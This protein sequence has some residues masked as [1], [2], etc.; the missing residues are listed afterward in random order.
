MA[1][2]STT[3]GTPV[4]SWRITRAGMKGTSTL[5]PLNMIRHYFFP[6]IYTQ[7]LLGLSLFPVENFFDILLQNLKVVAVPDRRLE[8]DSDGEW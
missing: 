4:K 1:A 2:K 5:S 7:F 8:K 3:A 6:I